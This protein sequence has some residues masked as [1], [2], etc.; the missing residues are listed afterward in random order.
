MAG[1][2]PAEDPLGDLFMKARKFFN[3]ERLRWNHVPSLGWLGEDSW[4]A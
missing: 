4:K 2:M 3:E 1:T